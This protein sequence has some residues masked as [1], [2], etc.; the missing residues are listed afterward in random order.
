MSPRKLVA[1]AAV[2][3]LSLSCGG[4]YEADAQVT[5]ADGQPSPGSSTSEVPP[6]AAPRMPAPPAAQASASGAP[7][8]GDGWDGNS[9]DPDH[10]PVV[11]R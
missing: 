7:S 8:N 10:G 3:A 5:G 11:Y 9:G 2:V 6:S 4:R 1:S